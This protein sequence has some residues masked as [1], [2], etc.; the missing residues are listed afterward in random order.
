MPAEKHHLPTV[1]G[2]LNGS[3]NKSFTVTTLPAMAIELGC[4]GSGK[5]TASVESPIGAFAIPC[6]QASEPFGATY[7]TAADNKQSKFPLG[8]H[9]Q[10]NITAPLGDTW[11]LWITGGSGSIHVAS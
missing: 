10:V 5:D 1:L 9:V 2:P 4:V 8:Q 7:V 3:G 11:Q 6:G